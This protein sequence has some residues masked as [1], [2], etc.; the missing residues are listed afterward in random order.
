MIECRYATRDS[1][2]LGVGDGLRESGGRSA[3]DDRRMGH[4]DED[5]VLVDGRSHDIGGDLQDEC[6]GCVVI[7]ECPVDRGRRPR[8]AGGDP[9]S[10]AGEAQKV[11]IVG[12]PLERPIRNPTSFQG[13]HLLTAERRFE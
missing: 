9:G 10:D 2:L 13:T 4:V 6:G 11:G 5:I 8:T 12:C 1:G 3:C 7:R